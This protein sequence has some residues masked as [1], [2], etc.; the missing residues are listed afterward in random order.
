MNKISTAFSFKTKEQLKITNNPAYN[1]MIGVF[2]Y[3]TIEEI[4]QCSRISKPWNAIFVKWMKL[5][6]IADDVDTKKIRKI[7]L[8]EANDLFDEAKICYSLQ[9]IN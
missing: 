7:S 1:T 8:F 9:D 5:V 4:L 6:N 3:L 2:K